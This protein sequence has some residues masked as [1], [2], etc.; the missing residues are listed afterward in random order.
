MSSPTTNATRNAHR[1]QIVSE[2]V[3]S[4]YIHEIA[5]PRRRRSPAPDRRTRPE[6]TELVTRS[7]LIA[8]VR[9]HARAM[10]ARRRQAL[11]L[12]A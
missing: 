12:G 4:A 7:P 8:R 10:P 5:T 11:E 3:M 6:S 9:D 1:T 2:A